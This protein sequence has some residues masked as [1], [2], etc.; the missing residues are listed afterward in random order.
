M[1]AFLSGRGP[2]VADATWSRTIVA[3]S[4]GSCSA[5]A[6]AAA[7]SITAVAATAAV[8]AMAAAA[9]ATTGFGLRTSVRCDQDQT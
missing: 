7:V 3:D 9:A 2:G 4:A 8:T 1:A 6:R 5:A